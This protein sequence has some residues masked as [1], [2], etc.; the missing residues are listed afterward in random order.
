LEEKAVS[1]PWRQGSRKL[2]YILFSVNGFT[3]EL[4]EQVNYREDV[5][6]QR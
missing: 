4:Q 1:V 5:I 3:K 6:L 2:W